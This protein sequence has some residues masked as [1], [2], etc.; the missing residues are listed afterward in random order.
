MERSHGRAADALRPV[1]FTRNFTDNAEGS[2]LVEFGRTRV[3]CTVTAV[4]GVPTFQANKKE[5]WLTAEYSM[6]PGSVEGRKARELGRRDGRSV[7]IQRLIGRSLRAVTDL[8][9]FPSW[10][11][12]ADCDV[13]QADG[14]TRCASITGAGLAL[15]DALRTLHGRNQIRHWPLRAWIA[16]ASVGNVAGRPLLD[17]D[18]GE[19][20]EAAVDMNVIGTSDGNLVEVQATA[21]KGT[22]SRESFDKLLDLGLEGVGELIALQRA[23]VEGGIPV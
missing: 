23:A 3:L 1:R 16:A 11:L 17:L 9:A 6:L 21:E 20:F 4:A 15:H 18:Y 19:D 7:E 5:G 14:S 8:S 2:V 22:V 12:F 10:T 13:L